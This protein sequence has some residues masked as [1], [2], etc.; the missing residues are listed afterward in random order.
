MQYVSSCFALCVT[1][2][3]PVDYFDSKPPSL[4]L[5]VTPYGCK[6]WF[7]MYRSN[8]RLR[9]LTLGTYP[10][11]S[12]A[13]ARQHAMATRHTVAQGVI[14]QPTSR[15]PALPRQSLISPHNT[16]NSMPKSTKRAGPM[17]RGS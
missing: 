2:A 1:Y 11:L 5:R 4:G 3:L 12:L 6:T 10:V 15:T 16:L 17:M 8:G 7:I 14:L 9:R 13:D